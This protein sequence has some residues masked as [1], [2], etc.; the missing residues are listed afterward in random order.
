M[1]LLRSLK[2]KVSWLIKKRVMQH[3]CVPFSNDG[4]EYKFLRLF[5]PSGTITLID[6]GASDGSFTAA[7]EKQFGIHRA[8][9]VE[10]IP[11][12]CVQLRNRFNPAMV[13][14]FEGVVSDH[15]GAIEM[16][17]LN[18]DYSSSILP[19][20]RDIQ[21]VAEA[22][23]LTVR[24]RITAKVQTLDGLVQ[25]RGF[26]GDIDLLKLDTQGSELMILHGATRT[27]ASTKFLLTEVSFKPLYKNSAV[28]VEIHDFLTSQGFILLSV[29]D[30]FRDADGEL[31]QADVL[32]G[33]AAPSSTCSSLK[34]H[35]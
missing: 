31:L 9:L 22:F 21:S 10:P 1:K 13:S 7:I 32:F 34:K 12:R 16:E 30:G 2:E 19:V 23:D 3:Y 18:W 4:L 28:F 5:R 6:V 35:K 27:L 11:E 14:I 33:R 26:F 17:I 15:A 29:M 24:K 20:R 25:E 8:L